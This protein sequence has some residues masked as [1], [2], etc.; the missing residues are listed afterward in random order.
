MHLGYKAIA[1]SRQAD[2][3]HHYQT[4]VNPPPARQAGTYNTARKGATYFEF[5]QGPATF[6]MMDT[7]TYR[8]ASR[9]VESPHKTMLGAEQL[10]D[11][12]AFLQKREPKGVK[13]KIVVSSVPF[14][15]NWRV[16]GLD[17]WL[18]Y[19]HERQIILESK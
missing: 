15:K 13:W 17:T 1:D 10:A 18:G 9:D 8:N 5:T 2:P 12:L 16:N 19:L 6:F 3:W 4:S 7:R 14:T 11:L